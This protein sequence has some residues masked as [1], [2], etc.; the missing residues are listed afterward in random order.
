MLARNGRLY[1]VDCLRTGV[2]EKRFFEVLY[3]W[4]KV[5]CEGAGFRG[6]SRASIHT[7]P[8][9]SQTLSHLR[10]SCSQCHFHQSS[11][12]KEKKRQATLT[13]SDDL[14][15][16]VR[17][18]MRSVPNPVVIITAS[19]SASSP[20]SSPPQQVKRTLYRGMTLSSFTSLSL[21]PEPH[22]TFNIRF[23]SRTL[24]ALIST[25]FFYLHILDASPDGAVIASAFT[26]GNSVVKSG[27]EELLF[28]S[29]AERGLLR[30]VELGG[31]GGHVPLLKGK[32]VKS[33]LFCRVIGEEGEREGFIR[34]GDHVLVIAKVL[35]STYMED[36]DS[37]EYVKDIAQEHG[38]GSGRVTEEAEEG[39]ALS[40][41]F[42]K[43]GRFQNMDAADTQSEKK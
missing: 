14:S 10:C 5:G 43:Y 7:R 33:R 3:R 16:Q 29:M 4:S 25:R 30:D 17:H 6:G 20:A 42:G 18:T 36:E 34:V 24:S 41:A 21:H 9:K 38:S 13:Q 32:G 15:S 8:R 35:P 39:V 31:K 2:A 40:Y 11:P 22:V 19:A 1:G 37:G 23:P 12:S 26:K 27:D 28:G